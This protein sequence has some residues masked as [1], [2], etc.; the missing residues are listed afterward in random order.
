MEKSFTIL[1]DTNISED[2]EQVRIALY[3]NIG[4]FIQVVQMLEYNL[5]KLICYVRSVNEIES[6]DINSERV[7][8]IHKKYD[9]YYLKTYK[10]KFTLGKLTKE[11]EK[12]GIIKEEVISFFIEINDYRIKVVHMIFQNNIYCDEL[13]SSDKV[14]EYMKQRLIPMI[15]KT[16]NL[17]KF[18]INCI[19]AYKDSFR[20]YKKDKH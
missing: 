3:A 20:E 1:T 2:N 4:F 16:E 8:N 11:V 14:L 12:L 13:K 18:V 6:G 17:N 10:D 19:D 5:R 7:E 15:T 9:D